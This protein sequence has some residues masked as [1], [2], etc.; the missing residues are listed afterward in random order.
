MADWTSTTYQ[1]I[2]DAVAAVSSY[3]SKKYPGKEFKVEYSDDENEQVDDWAYANELNECL[4]DLGEQL[5]STAGVLHPAGG[6]IK[7]DD[8]E[9]KAGVTFFMQWADD[10]TWQPGDTGLPV[11]AHSGSVVYTNNSADPTQE[12]VV[13][14][15]TKP[16]W[17]IHMPAYVEKC[18]QEVAEKRYNFVSPSITIALTQ[19]D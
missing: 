18:L 11:V 1:K 19:S 4:S 9:N 13:A 5:D 6:Q 8:R 3:L 7:P 12:D 2:S 10:P 16:E 17:P 14:L 15:I